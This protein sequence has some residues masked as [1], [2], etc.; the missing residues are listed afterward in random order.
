MVVS[1]FSP[2]PFYLIHNFG[3][4]YDAF[5]GFSVAVKSYYH[6]WLSIWCEVAVQKLT[7][8]PAPKVFKPKYKLPVLEDYR[9]AAPTSFWNEFPSNKVKPA[10]SL[11]DADTLEDMALEVGGVDAKILAAICNDLGKG[12][13]LGCA[14]LFRGSTRAANAPSAFENGQKVTDAICDWLNKG[15]AYGPVDLD[16]IPENAKVNCVMTRPKPNG[17]VRIILNLSSPRGVSVNDGID[18]DDFPAVMSST[19]K[20]LAALNKAGR[21]CKIAKVDW[22]DAYKHV[23][24]HQSDLDLQWFTW[25]GKAFCELCLVFGCASSAGIFDRLAKVVLH[26]VIKRSGMDPAL[27]IQHLDDC[28]A[29]APSDSVMLEQFDSEFFA[30]AERLGIK[31]AP[32][33][34]PTKSFGPSYAG[35]ILGVHYDTV[36]WTW[37]MPEE[38][39]L[40]LLHDL[41]L[42]MDSDFLEQEKIWSIVGKLINV[43]PLVP[44]GRFNMY[45][46]VLSN[47][48][49]KHPWAMVPIDPE[50]KRQAW[51]WLTTLQVCCGRAQ[52]PDP[53]LGLPPW[54]VEIYT[55]AAGGS[56]KTRGLGVGAVAPTFWV[57]L[58]WGRA[59]NAGRPTGDYRRL[60]RIMSAL[61]LMG[62]LLALCAGHTVLRGS[63]VRFFVDNAGSV[64]IFRKGYS[65]SCRYS[66]AIVAA[67]GTVAAGLGCRVELKKI[68]RCSTD[69]ALMADLISKGALLRFWEVAKQAVGFHCPL[70]PAR[71]PR[72]LLKWVEDPCPDF[73]LGDALLRELSK[74]GEVLG[75]S[76]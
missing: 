31:L 57:V 46:L 59:I 30:V 58:P 7:P 63:A 43:R 73:G 55:D 41:R 14:E 11:V 4:L 70:Q 64:F 13:R 50:L 33:D 27:V 60:D 20:W 42:L 66:S 38:K 24:V 53:S 36:A 45:H 62:P 25:L 39:L 56:T 28:C 76:V 5:L 69:G 40:R 37:A 23:A 26:I 74:Q 2:N 65:T 71:V 17:S 61:E 15:F 18:S 32:R 6:H 48:F 12:A 54:T 51:F 52:I 3:G 34:D 67:I 21:G 29:A 49:S 10:W 8:L 16:Q 47:S 1:P 22:S 68:T 19:T 75:Y 44:G 9:K 35:V 72:T